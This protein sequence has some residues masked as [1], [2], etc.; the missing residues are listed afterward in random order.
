[1]IFQRGY[2]RKNRTQL[3]RKQPK[4]RILHDFQ[5]GDPRKNRAQLARKQPKTWIC[6]DFHR[7]GPRK[8]RAQLTHLT[9]PPKELGKEGSG[10][11]E[12]REGAIQDLPGM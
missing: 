4:T 3:A 9:P 8:T 5:R 6:H 1:M 10:S 2:P 7:G 12:V 11:R